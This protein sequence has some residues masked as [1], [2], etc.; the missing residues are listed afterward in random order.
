[1]SF[2]AHSTGSLV[3]VTSTATGSESPA[4]ADPASA[5]RITMIADTT[6]RNLLS[7]LFRGERIRVRDGNKL[8]SQRRPL[9]PIVSP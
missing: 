4:V 1:L 9:T 2:S 8:R 5:V 3:F 7:P 6:A